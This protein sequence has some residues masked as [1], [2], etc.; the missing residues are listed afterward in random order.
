MVL[1][2]PPVLLSLTFLLSKT[3]AIYAMLASTLLLVHLDD[4]IP[5]DNNNININSAFDPQESE[6]HPNEERGNYNRGYSIN[7]VVG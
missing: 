6:S 3:N 4:N 1:M 2:V 5:N 7:T